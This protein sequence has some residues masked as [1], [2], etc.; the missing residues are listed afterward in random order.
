MWTSYLDLLHTFNLI[1]PCYAFSAILG[2]TCPMTV[3][4]INL[5]ICFGRKC[6]KIGGARIASAFTTVQT[7]ATT[8]HSVLHLDVGGWTSIV[9]YFVVPNMQN[10]SPAMSTL[11]G[12]IGEMHHNIMLMF[13][14]FL[15]IERIPPGDDPIVIILFEV[16]HFLE[17]IVMMLSHNVMFTLSLISL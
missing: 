4:N 3:M 14:I 9:L 10:T 7:N 6:C 2:T 11:K 16:H 13:Q 15:D 5:V 17:L 1:L 8:S 12:N